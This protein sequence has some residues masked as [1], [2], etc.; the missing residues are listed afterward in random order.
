MLKTHF[1]LVSHFQ[2]HITH[3]PTLL[4]G[5]L[6]SSGS[7]ELN[8]SQLE[9]SR[10]QLKH[11]SDFFLCELQHFQRLLLRKKDG[12]RDRTRANT[13]VRVTEVQPH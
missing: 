11:I 6:R 13:E 7:H 9:D 4:G 8:V 10:Q 5:D 2:T 12:V 3:K 1:S